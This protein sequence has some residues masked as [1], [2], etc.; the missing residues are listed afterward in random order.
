MLSPSTQV[1]RYTRRATGQTGNIGKAI[2][3]EV[4]GQLAMQKGT[5]AVG[6]VITPRRVHFKDKLQPDVPLTT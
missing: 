6:I 2:C 3:T 5:E 1:C 4:V